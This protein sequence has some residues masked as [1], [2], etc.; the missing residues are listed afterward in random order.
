MN[1]ESKWMPVEEGLPE[2]RETYK[3]GPRNARVMVYTGNYVTEGCYEETY[4]KR[5]PVWKNSR[6]RSI[7]VT[8]WQPLPEP[9]K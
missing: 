9:P 6:D 8:H 2:M 3:G 7:T 4:V 5:K 1:Q